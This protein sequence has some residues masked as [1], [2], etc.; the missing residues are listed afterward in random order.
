LTSE[1]IDL[2]KQLAGAGEGGRTITA[3]AQR[4]GM[5]RLVEAGYATEQA[6]SLATNLYVITTLGRKVFANLER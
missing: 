6:V 4:G 3:P 2:L 1:E 5:T